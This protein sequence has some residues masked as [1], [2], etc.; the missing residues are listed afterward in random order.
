EN[1]RV[2]YGFNTGE[3]QRA[4][5]RHQPHRSA[6]RGLRTR[7]VQGRVSREPDPDDRVQ[8]AGQRGCGDARAASR[9]G[10]G[11]YG[12]AEGQPVSGEEA[13]GGRDFIPVRG[14]GQTRQT[15]GTRVGG[16]TQK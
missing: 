15:Q 1:G 10:R 3:G 14:R 9:K 13:G 2:P 8:E 4:G 6:G 11:Y 5:A 12:S 16:P 7:K